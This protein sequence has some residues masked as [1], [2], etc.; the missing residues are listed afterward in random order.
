MLQVLTLNVWF[1]DKLRDA[2]TKALLEVIRACAPAVCCLQEVVPEVAALLVDGLPDWNSSDPGDGSTLAPYG[3][4]VLARPGL[5]ARFS[6]H[7]LPTDMCR[8]LLV[9]ELPGLT[10]G[11]VHLE[12]LANHPTR[13]AQLQACAAVLAAFPDAV[14]VGDF[15]FDSDRNFRPPHD[16]LENLALQRFM[17]DFVDVWSALRP[18]E[19][20]LTFDSATNPYIQAPEHMRYDR[21]L[22]RLQ[23][24]SATSIELVGDTPVDHLVE[25]S[26]VEIDWLER[27]PTPP[28]PAPGMRKC[29]DFGF[30]G[31]DL[32]PSTTCDAELSPPASSADASAETPSP[33]KKTRLFL[34]DHFGL[35]VSFEELLP[36]NRELN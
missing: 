18:S 33:R 2:R 34:S 20:G 1:G 16:P 25:L 23:T 6:F 31:F 24:W 36:R 13:E 27:P 3:V 10:V 8:R 28:R 26:A 35:L 11:T 30:G 21:V 29:P 5:S 22:A 12:S 32:E 4:M 7:D 19:R 9:A 14:L 17:P 15:N